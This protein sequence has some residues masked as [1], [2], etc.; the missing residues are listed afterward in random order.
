[1]QICKRRGELSLANFSDNVTHNARH[2][3][4]KLD[5]S[6]IEAGKKFLNLLVK[7]LF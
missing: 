4:E 7:V 5:L 2:L 6:L 1:M 3:L